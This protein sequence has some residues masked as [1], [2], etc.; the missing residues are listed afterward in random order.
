MSLVTLNHPIQLRVTERSQIDDARDRESIPKN[1]ILDEIEVRLWGK[2]KL[3]G[4]TIDLMRND[5]GTSGFGCKLSF[6]T[7]DKLFSNNRIH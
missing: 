7:R 5:I 6:K 4:V 1:Q 3:K 2:L